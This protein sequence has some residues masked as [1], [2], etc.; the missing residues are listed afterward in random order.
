VAA[1]V[2][3]LLT[4]IGTYHAYQLTDSVRFRGRLCHSVVNSAIGPAG[5]LALKRRVARRATPAM[6]GLPIAA[7]HLM[8][9]EYT[10][11][12]DSPHARVACVQW[13]IGPGA[14]WFVRYKFTGLYQV[15]ATMADKYP[16]PISSPVKNVRPAQ[17]TCEQC[18][19]PRKF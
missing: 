5:R 11:Y 19:W 16:R 1:F 12:E 10:A 4:S 15:Y 3:A 17:A 7:I 6:P 2:F 13:H 9:P 14:A 8:K 18:H